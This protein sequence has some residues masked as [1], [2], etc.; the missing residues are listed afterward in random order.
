MRAFPSSSH[1]SCSAPNGPRLASSNIWRSF[2]GC[3]SLAKS[4][5]F[6]WLKQAATG[7]RSAAFATVENN[8]MI[9]FDRNRHFPGGQ[10]STLKSVQACDDSNNADNAEDCTSYL[11]QPPICGQRTL[12]LPRR[13]SMPINQRRLH[14]LICRQP[15]LFIIRVQVRMIEEKNFSAICIVSMVRK[16][17]R[18]I[19]SSAWHDSTVCRG[20]D[21]RLN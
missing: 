6:N 9:E 13:N 14:R 11:P 4:C 10:R 1:N 5:H 20:L 2:R 8:D 12:V 16:W 7:R 18:C 3:G 15:P 19:I 17:I 21:G